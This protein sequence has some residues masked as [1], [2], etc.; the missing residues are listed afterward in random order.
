MM[1]AFLLLC[2]GIM[3]PAAAAPV[4]ICLFEKKV[5]LAGHATCG[6]NST[7]K[8]KCC[9]DCGSTEMDDSCCIEINKLP[10][11]TIPAPPFL[12]F[13]NLS[14]LAPLVVCV[15]P[16]PVMELREPFVPSVPIRGPDLPGEWRALLGVW[17]I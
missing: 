10:A 1:A 6:E 3:I 13:P 17:N 7:G 12:L 9:A 2:Y 15:P 11:A 4:R 14:C 5:D 8:V 16:C